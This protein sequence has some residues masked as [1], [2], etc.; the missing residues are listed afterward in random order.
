MFIKNNLGSIFQE[1]FL[2]DSLTVCENID[3]L[4]TLM[5]KPALESDRKVKELAEE[6]TGQKY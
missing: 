6:L 4:L 3:V 2:L 5:Q 1:Y